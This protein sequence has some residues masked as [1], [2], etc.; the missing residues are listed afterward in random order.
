M[1]VP[2]WL[3]YGVA[4]FVPY[5]QET[6]LRL[7]QQINTEA[8]LLSVLGWLGPVIMAFLAT[9]TRYYRWAIAGLAA[10]WAWCGYWFFQRFYSQLNWAAEIIAWAFFCQSL[11]FLLLLSGRQTAYLPCKPAH[12]PTPLTVW[13]PWTLI[14]MAIC[15]PLLT[16]LVG[17]PWPRWEYFAFYPDATALFTLG[18]VLAL[19][20]PQKKA[21]LF[22][23]LLPIP[24]LWCLFSSAMLGVI[25]QPTVYFIY[26]AL[27]LVLATLAESTWAEYS[28]S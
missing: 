6:Y 17:R 1:D 2:D 14:A 16:Y 21:L 20:P 23:L 15:W 13:L 5:T 11:L 4:D 10:S 25:E 27:L 9:K 22:S 8:G 28:A 18:F 26:A 7:A 3:T 19:R 24:I 12:R